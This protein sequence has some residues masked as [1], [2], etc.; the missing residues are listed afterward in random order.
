MK[1][2]LISLV[3][4]LTLLTAALTGCGMSEE[5]LDLLKADAAAVF[6]LDVNPGVRVYVDEDNAV[7]AVE[8]TNEDGEEIAS[9][10]DLAGED[11][12]T[13]V[14]EIVDKMDEKGYLEGDAGS[15]LVSVEKKEIE[16]SEKIN[17]KLNKVFKK[18]G[19][20]VAVI[21]QDLAELE[22]D[23][24]KALGK[25]AKKYNISE[26]KARL[27]EKI[28]EEYKNETRTNRNHNK[29]TSKSRY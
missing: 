23:A 8:A 19:K 6:T 2:I 13:A 3:L 9:E 29:R 16:V 4:V 26:G 11:Y 22:E 28:R 7:I 15:V 10:L 27:V 5:E 18:H 21:E 24:T 12:E 14:E 17:E 25:I 1:K 20:K